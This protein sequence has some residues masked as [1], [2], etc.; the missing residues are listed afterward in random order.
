MHKTRKLT[1]FIFR[2]SPPW[3]MQFALVRHCQKLQIIFPT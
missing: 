2:P 1:T 3:K